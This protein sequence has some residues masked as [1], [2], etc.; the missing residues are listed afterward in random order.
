MTSVSDDS[1]PTLTNGAA[2]D[3]LLDRAVQGAHAF[4]DQVAEKAGPAVDQ[5][6]S[7]AERVSES[8]QNGAEEFSDLHA[9]VMDSCRASIRDH[10]LTSIG[11]AVVAGLILSRVL[12]R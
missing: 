8:I 2:T 7:S 10:P 12:Q 5:L 6:R 11:V 4:V 9:R 1:N 3:E